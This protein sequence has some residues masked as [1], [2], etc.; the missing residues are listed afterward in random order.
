MYQ[1]RET[2]GC[3]GEL[4]DQIVFLRDHEKNNSF[5]VTT[6]ENSQRSV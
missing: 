2:P 5:F 4:L 1:N 6:S 3:T